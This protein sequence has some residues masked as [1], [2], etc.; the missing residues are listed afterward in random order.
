MADGAAG[1]D[2]R[3]F[4]VTFLAHC[5]VDAARLDGLSLDDCSPELQALAALI[6]TDPHEVRGVGLV[7]L[8]QLA[9]LS[10]DAV[11]LATEAGALT[12]AELTDA[13]PFTGV[14]TRAGARYSDVATAHRPRRRK[15]KVA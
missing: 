11:L 5:L 15:R 14:A 1:A 7:T 12:V 6:A 9:G 8:A 4:D 3:D 2:G 10:D 13:G